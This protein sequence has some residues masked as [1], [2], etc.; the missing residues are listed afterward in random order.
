MLIGSKEW[1]FGEI[2][3]GL[4]AIGN[5]QLPPRVTEGIKFIWPGDEQIG[6]TQAAFF[7]SHGLVRSKL[8]QLIFSHPRYQ[9][10]VLYNT[11]VADCEDSHHRN[12]TI[13]Y[14]WHWL[15]N[16]IICKDQ[17]LQ[18]SRINSIR[19]LYSIEQSLSFS[20]GYTKTDS[21][22]YS[23][24]IIGLVSIQSISIGCPWAVR[25]EKWARNLQVKI[26]TNPKL[27]WTQ[28]PKPVISLSIATLYDISS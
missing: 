7:S 8:L 15:S 18:R 12:Q 17:A 5:P 20:E 24:W 9:L 2:F 21:Y 14:L 19:C 11:T 25:S 26:E 3:S 6:I 23:L 28:E 4:L 16:V 13:S 22:S 10:I 27:Y 1:R